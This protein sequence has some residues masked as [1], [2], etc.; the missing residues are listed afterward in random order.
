MTIVNG[1]DLDKFNAAV[2]AVRG[3]P[4]SGKKAITIETTWLG[5][6]ASE[7]KIGE[8]TVRVDEPVELGGTNTGPTPVKTTLAALGS[9]LLIGFAANAAIMGIE[10]QSMRIVTEGTLDLRGFFGLSG[11]IRPGL[12]TLKFTTYIRSNAPKE[13]LEALRGLVERTSPCADI[14]ANQIK[15]LNSEIVFE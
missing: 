4:D 3:N 12:Q 1:I 11:D 15:A 5:G 9:C 10:I 2:A 7:S 13:K 8:F 6:T 14:C